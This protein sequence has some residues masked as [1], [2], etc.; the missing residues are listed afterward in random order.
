MGPDE[1]EPDGWVPV[2]MSAE[3]ALAEWAQGEWVPPEMVR[4]P[5]EPAL[6]QPRLTGSARAAAPDE[7]SVELESAESAPSER[8]VPVVVTSSAT[9]GRERV[10]EWKP[11]PGTEPEPVLA[12]EPAS[13][14]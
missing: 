14:S 13:A 7:R 9:P 8:A 12:R 1:P 5:A 6:V 2:E 3:R 10:P 4:E 11:A